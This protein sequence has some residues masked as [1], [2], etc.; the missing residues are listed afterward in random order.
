MEINNTMTVRELGEWL[1]A[2][3]QYL[4]EKIVYCDGHLPSSTDKLC[5]GDWGN[6]YPFQHR[7][8]LESK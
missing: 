3:E 6:H 8:V 7:L 5:F 4:D 1:L 2:Q